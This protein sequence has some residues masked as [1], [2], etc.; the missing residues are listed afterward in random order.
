MGGTR[1][2]STK[3]CTDK[4]ATFFSI[5]LAVSCSQENCVACLLSIPILRLHFDRNEKKLGS[6]ER[7]ALIKSLQ[8]DIDKKDQSRGALKHIAVAYKEQTAS[9]PGEK[10]CG[11]A[12]G[13]KLSN[14]GGK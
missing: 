5:H 13:K 14:K 1:K 7:T 4:W 3:V 10:K 12:C 9:F 11:A 2:D 6:Q 8:G